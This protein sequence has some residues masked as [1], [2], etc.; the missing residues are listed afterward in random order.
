MSTRNSSNS[1]V[2][3]LFHKDVECNEC[4]EHPILGTRY[5]STRRHN[6]DIC[7]L[8]FQE[9]HNGDA[10]DFAVFDKRAATPEELCGI[11][12]RQGRAVVANSIEELTERLSQ[13]QQPQQE[14]DEAE[15]PAEDIELYLNLNRFS[16][17]PDATII[18]LRLAM[19][20][21]KTVKSLRIFLRGT[22]NLNRA[23]QVLAEALVL[24]KSIRYLAVS[25][26]ASRRQGRADGAAQALQTLLTTNRTIRFFHFK[27]VSRFGLHGADGEGLGQDLV[28][29]Y[30]FSA[31]ATT[32]L[33]RFLYRGGHCNVS[34]C[35]RQ[36]ACEAMK[37]NPHLRRIEATFDDHDD[38]EGE[39]FQ[40][41]LLTGIKNRQWMDRWIGEAATKQDR[42]N[43]L[44]E[45]LQRSQLADKTSAM[46]HFLRCHPRLLLE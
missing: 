25:V 30:L 10:G 8:C 13:R 45:I 43:V 28:A 42:V 27:T 24:N 26:C 18:R 17:F 32:T 29:D 34:N 5:R 6:Y 23:M 41:A 21:N 37:S 1:S 19:V 4:G 44:E 20:Q 36:R 7:Q 22:F 9:H 38:D 40:L 14:E 12:P 2:P 3:A 35:N 39:D 33:C 46:Y 11:C 16:T 15:S 31:L